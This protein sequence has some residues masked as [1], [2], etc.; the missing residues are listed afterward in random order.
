MRG[1]GSLISSPKLLSCRRCAWST[2]LRRLLYIVLLT[3]AKRI[4]HKP[5]QVK[6]IH[7]GTDGLEL[8]QVPVLL[9]GK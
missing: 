6:L 4:A 2:A 8:L 7:V 5:E 3:A 9:L 1:L